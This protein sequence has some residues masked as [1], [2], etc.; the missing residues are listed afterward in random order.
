MSQEASKHKE[1][2]V[3]RAQLLAGPISATE[4]GANRRQSSWR[5]FLKHLREMH[6]GGQVRSQAA[7]TQQEEVSNSAFYDTRRDGMIEKGIFQL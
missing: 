6:D 3:F 5:I 4:V 1:I 7:E 2:S